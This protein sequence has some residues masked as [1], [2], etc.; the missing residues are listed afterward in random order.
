[1]PEGMKNGKNGSNGRMGKAKVRDLTHITTRTDTR[2]ILAHA[3]KDAKKLKDYFI[4]DTDAHV[5]EAI[6]LE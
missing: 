4:V 6:V 1:M 2:D 5:T 3:A